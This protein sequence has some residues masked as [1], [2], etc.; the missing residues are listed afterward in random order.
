[1]NQTLLEITKQPHI[2]GLCHSWLETKGETGCRVTMINDKLLYWFLIQI[3]GKKK[4]KKKDE[5]IIIL[6]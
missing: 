2:A 3:K 1:M 6:L 4:K 5:K